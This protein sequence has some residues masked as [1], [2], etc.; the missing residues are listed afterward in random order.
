MNKILYILTAALVL[1]AAASCNDAQ[2]YADI[3]SAE[4]EYIDHLILSENISYKSISDETLS[5]WTKAVQKDSVD[6]ATFIDLGQWYTITEGD[7]KRLYFKVNKWGTGYDRWKKWQAY[8]D[9]LNQS[10]SPKHRP[11]SVSYYDNK[12]VSGSYVLVRYD[13]LFLMSDSLD[14]HKDLPADNLTP[15]SYQIIFGWN[16]Y[17]YA[18][19]Y[20]SYSF[21]SNSSYACTSG[22]LAFPLRF[23]WY[24]SEVSLIVPFSLVPS[25]YS[26]YYYT[27]YYGKVKYSKPNYLPEE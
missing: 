22:G 24:D 23:L 1:F 18:S 13:S 6:P 11:D 12:V 21:G 27:L 10:L 7:F 25:D 5:S 20:Y 17:Y 3:V 2:T 15:Y 26:N 9:S 4:E 14:I 16:D 8:K 19:T